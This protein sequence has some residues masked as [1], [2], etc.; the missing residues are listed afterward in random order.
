MW[1]FGE[2]SRVASFPIGSIG[3]VPVGPAAPA[4][5]LVLAVTPGS[6]SEPPAVLLWV[7]D[8]S[9]SELLLS[10]DLVLVDGLLSDTEFISVEVLAPVEDLLSVRDLLSVEDFLSLIGLLWEGSSFSEG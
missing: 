2:L 1:V 10:K 6:V 8:F 7:D 4:G 5:V 3:A 9:S